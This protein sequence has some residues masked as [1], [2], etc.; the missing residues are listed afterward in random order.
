MRDSQLNERY[1]LMIMSAFEQ[2]VSFDGRV[3]F[4]M[5]PAE[6][7]DLHAIEHVFRFILPSHFGICTRD[8]KLALRDDIRVVR[9]MTNDIVEG[10]DST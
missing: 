2:H 7:I 4:G 6:C 5:L 1:R 9:I 10:T 3:E 8:P